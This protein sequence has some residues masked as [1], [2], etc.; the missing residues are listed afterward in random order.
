[1]VEWLSNLSRNSK[2]LLA[3]STDL[4]T[5]PTALWLSFALRLEEVYAPDVRIATTM[6]LAT[7]TTV[8]VFVRL[9][10]YRAVIRYAGLQ[11]F[12]TIFIGVS[13]SVFLLAVLAFLFQAQM[14]RS[15]PFIYFGI[16]LIAV[17]ATR[18]LIRHLLTIDRHQKTKKVIIYGAGSA[19][20]QLSNALLQGLEYQPVG[21]V[22]DDKL[23]QGSE[24]NGLR[25]YKPRKL[26]T[27]IAEFGVQEVLLAISTLTPSRRGQIVHSLAQFNVKVKTIPG[28]L[29]LIDG[30]SKIE[31]IR[32]LKVE[33][34]LGR[35]QVPPD[36]LL[37]NACVKGKA[38]LVTGAGG[39]I[40]SELCRQ[41]AE[42][43]PSQL[44]I[45]ES[46]E[47][48]L[49]SI[50]EE[51]TQK[52]YDFPILPMLGNV[53]DEQLVLRILQ[54]FSI[55][56]VYHSAA[57]K[58]VPLVE[59]NLAAGVSNNI[60]GT[61]ATANA[62]KTA[63]VRNFILISTDKAVRPTNIMG[64]TKRV[65][66]QILQNL[67]E[68][69]DSTT[70]FT[71]VRFGNVLASSGSVV[72]K[73]KQQIESGGPVTVTHPEI[74]RYFMTIPEAVQLVIQAGTLGEGGD[75]FVLDM[76]EPVKI[77][78]LAETIIVLLGKSLRTTEFQEGEIEIKYTGLRPGEKL[79]EELLIGENCV[80]TA[81][82]MITRAIESKLK[83]PQLESVIDCLREA[84][85]SDDLLQ[86]VQQ[87][88]F[89]VPEYSA[90][91]EV[92]KLISRAEKVKPTMLSI[93][94]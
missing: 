58:H 60:L 24:I 13:V 84:C 80:G 72:P 15:V 43:G 28:M 22:D 78:N 8:A 47:F 39:S 37:L 45:F 41:I 30:T 91:K 21:F 93:K 81:H 76:G 79:Y 16:A 31:E 92:L 10:L 3:V 88:E 5:I 6:A 11:M 62:A 52:E 23:K 32:N 87:L 29:E 65:A 33:E 40:G 69:K 74:T 89:A 4:V 67:A 54:K 82:P 68:S 94:P 17:S 90:S 38:V 2:R 75:V 27:L 53:Q 50:E 42:I 34:L 55:K 12:N 19:G 59:Q 51:L 46:S 36:P 14:P 73:F 20:L 25:V 26:C 48:A 7:L 63:G 57:Y 85:R 66:E 71:M 9:G 61:Y 64:A 18:L 44:I 56:T 1:M 49:Y 77:K 83:S 35:E 70:T 86:I